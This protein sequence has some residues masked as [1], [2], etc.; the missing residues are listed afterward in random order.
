M[1]KVKNQPRKPKQSA[2]HSPSTPSRAQ[3][4]DKT[5][6]ADLKAGQ[7]RPDPDSADGSGDMPMRASRKKE[8][9]FGHN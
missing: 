6:L 5:M 7:H 2:A 9:R 1:T 8:K 4:H 3:M